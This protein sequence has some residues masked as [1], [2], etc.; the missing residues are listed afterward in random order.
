VC[1]PCVLKPDRRPLFTRP[2]RVWR[3]PCGRGWGCP[4]AHAARSS[5]REHLQSF[6]FLAAPGQCGGV[7]RAGMR[8]TC[9]LGVRQRMWHALPVVTA[10]VACFAPVGCLGWTIAESSCRDA[11]CGP[12]TGLICRLPCS[13]VNAWVDVIPYGRVPEPR[14]YHASTGL[15]SVRAAEPFAC[16]AMHAC[17]IVLSCTPGIYGGA[18]M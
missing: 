18:L 4:I 7:G 13:Q 9:G 16:M 17:I 12:G 10:A 11:V 5:T 1:V 8:P 15:P 3:S 2:L 14:A 6:H